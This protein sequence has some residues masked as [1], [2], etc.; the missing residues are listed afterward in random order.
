MPVGEP[1][2]TS[3][4]AVPACG[5]V[6]ACR[7]RPQPVMLTAAYSCGS[8]PQLLGQLEHVGRRHGEAER[9]KRDGHYAPRL[10]AHHDPVWA[11]HVP[12]FLIEARPLLFA[13]F[14]S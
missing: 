9:R 4:G 1:E 12:G 11:R 8:Y 6:P 5:S 13:A 2:N 3:I 7:N 10:G 14:V